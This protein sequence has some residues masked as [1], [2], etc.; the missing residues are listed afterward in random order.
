MKELKFNL[1]NA[2]NM[3]AQLESNQFKS[4]AYKNAYW[5]LSKVDESEIESKSNFT[6]L[7][8]VGKGISD[9]IIEYRET[10][11]IDKLVVLMAEKGTEISSKDYKVRKGFITKRISL[12][13]A[14]MIIKSL[15]IKESDSLMFVG[16]YRRK[17]NNIADIDLLT[18]TDPE[19]WETVGKLS[20]NNALTLLVSGSEKSSFRY[21]NPENTQ[22]DVNCGSHGWKG[23]QLIHHTGSKEFNIKLRGIAKSLGYKLNQYGLDGFH[24]NLSSELD[25]FNALNI[26]YIEPWNR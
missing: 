2:L 19:Y 17:L 12:S 15:G 23:T 10:G 3:L 21:N 20:E 13:H 9:K 26:E 14:D 18:F 24:G 5:T 6:Y 16:S 22:I 4:K 7:P 11:K 25:V 1:L 8:G